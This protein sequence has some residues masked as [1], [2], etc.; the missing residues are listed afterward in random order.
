MNKVYTPALKE[1]NFLLK[2]FSVSCHMTLPPIAKWPEPR[3][4]RV[5]PAWTAGRCS[6]YPMRSCVQLNK[7]E[8]VTIWEGKWV[9]EN[10]WK[11]ATHV[12]LLNPETAKKW[13]LILGFLVETK[14][15][16]SNKNSSNQK[17]SYLVPNYLEDCLAHAPKMF[18]E[19]MNQGQEFC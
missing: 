8:S 17:T 11:P 15:A 14:K 9:L 7:R 12:F 1:R 16:F 13:R 4:L 3:P 18:I 6:L 2:K 10:N 19:W 5:L